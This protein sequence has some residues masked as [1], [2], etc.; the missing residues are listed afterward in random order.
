MNLADVILFWVPEKVEVIEGRDYAQT[1]RTEFGEYTAK[2]KKIIMGIHNDFSGR[3]YFKT[4]CDVFGIKLHDNV[5]DCIAELK[6]YV[7]ECNKVK[8]IY[9]TSD[10]HFGS[11]RTLELSKRPFKS[12]EEMDMVM[13]QRWNDTVHPNDEI[14]HLGDFGNMEYLKYLNGYKGFINGNYERDEDD[15]EGLTDRQREKKYLAAGFDWYGNNGYCMICKDSKGKDLLYNIAHEPLRCIKDIN[16]I[17][18]TEPEGKNEYFGLFGHIHGRQFIKDFGIDCG[19]DCNNFRPVSVERIEFFRNAIQKGF[20][21]EEVWCNGQSIPADGSKHKVFLGGTCNNTTW[22]KELIPELKIDYFNPVVKDWTEEAKKN[23]EKEKHIWCDLQL[24]V[25]TP[26]MTG[27]FSIAEVV[28]SAVNSG[29]R[30]VLCVLDKD[31]KGSKEIEFDEGQK[32]SLDA[33]KNMV[34]KYGAY[35]CDNLKD[36]AKYLNNFDKK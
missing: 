1:T 29:K 4:K 13:I 25:L 9:F 15:K 24:Y 30:T 32:R 34:K 8:K 17:R 27:T 28:E 23:E 19:V 6:E 7:K 22:R 14:Y 3:R 11:E 5:E 36:V 31:K 18:E 20:Y 26:R 16:F 2:G 33:L 10:T 12:V 35:V 21:D